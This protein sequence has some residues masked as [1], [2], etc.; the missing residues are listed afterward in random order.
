LTANVAG[1]ITTSTATVTLTPGFIAATT[2]GSTGLI[3]VSQTAGLTPGQ[4]ITGTGVPSNGYIAQGGISASAATV[5]M[6]AVASATS[7]AAPTG[8]VT[9]G[10]SVITSVSSVSGIL[11]GLPITGTG[12]PAGT[13]VVG[14]DPVGLTITM[15]TTAT[16]T[17]TGTSSVTPFAFL[18]KGSNVITD[19][20]SLSGLAA[21]NKVTGLGIPANTVIGSVG[22]I[23]TATLAVGGTT[24]PY[25]T[26]AL[27]SATSTTTAG[28]SVNAILQSGNN[29]VAYVTPIPYATAFPSTF[30][31]GQLITDAQG[32][33]APNTTVTGV[34]AGN[35]TIAMSAPAPGATTVTPVYSFTGTV[36]VSYEI[37]SAIPAAAFTA[38]PSGSSVPYLSLGVPITGPNISYGTV[39]TAINPP[40]GTQTT[41]TITINSFPSAAAGAEL[42][43]ASLAILATTTLS[44]QTLPKIEVIAPTTSETVTIPAVEVVTQSLGTVTLSQAPTV[45]GGN[46]TSAQTL[47]VEG[48]DNQDVLPNDPGTVTFAGI[49]TSG[50]TS[51]TTVSNL[52]GL[53]VGLLVGGPG[54]QA[55]TTIATI[56]APS[57]LTLSLAPTAGSTSS[58]TLFAYLPNAAALA[59]LGPQMLSEPAWVST[60]TYPVGAPVQYSGVNYV[61][62][63]A[64]TNVIPSGNP[65]TWQ[66]TPAYYGGFFD[67]AGASTSSANNPPGSV[68]AR[69]FSQVLAVLYG[70]TTPQTY[71]GGFFPN[72]VAGNINFV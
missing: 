16:S 47:I 2:K 34:S 43:G 52:T 64:N 13:T 1:Q 22:A 38:T 6:S 58:T 65:A 33:I 28:S 70:S 23:N 30:T 63:V 31:T 67:T 19:L 32:N 71:Q 14:F 62:I 46:A 29:N 12:I 39:V 41:G 17:T 25:S 68:F 36:V 48:T 40:T 3:Y 50:S 9:A 18:T 8:F 27:A 24:P 54:I 53:A 37:I 10:T 26:P 49:V 60:T 4:L 5:V 7:S 69:T 61:A 42:V 51:V 11:P 21:G 44:T 55:G 72:G 15:S 35:F 56:T 45:F 57:S 20:S 66:S 59:A